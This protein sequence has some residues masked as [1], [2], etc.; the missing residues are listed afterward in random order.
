MNH[1]GILIGAGVFVHFAYQMKERVRIGRNVH[2][3]PLGV[4]VLNNQ[5][6][7]L[8]LVVGID[9]GQRQGVV[10][11]RDRRRCRDSRF[12]MIGDLG[13]RMLR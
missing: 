2:V 13:K 8:V 12:V 7:L 4:V 1:D 10:D 5:T 6:R 11:R 3:L 9:G